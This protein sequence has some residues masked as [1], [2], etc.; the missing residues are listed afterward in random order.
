MNFAP[1]FK[2]SL[3]D[4]SRIRPQSFHMSALHAC[5]IS[6]AKSNKFEGFVFAGSYSG[7]IARFYVFDNKAKARTCAYGHNAKIVQF[8]DCIVPIVKNCVV[9]LSV[10]GTI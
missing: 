7:A 1:E 4:W 3:T 8:D 5:R 2:V 9:S 6:I 10:D